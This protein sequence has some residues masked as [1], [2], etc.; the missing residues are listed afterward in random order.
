MYRKLFFLIS[1]ILV[2][3]LIVETAI[4]GPNHPFL[5]VA[6]SNYPALRAL[7]EQLPWSQMKTDAISDVQTLVYNSA[8]DYEKKAQLMGDIVSA[9]ALAY[10]LDPSNSSTYISKVYDTMVN[11][12][13]DLWAG[14]D[15]SQHS[16]TV[17]PGSAFFN[18]VLALDIMYNDLKPAQRADIEA[19]LQLVADWYN[20][21]N[22]SWQLNLYGVRGI[23]A[24]YK[25]DR[26]RIDKAKRD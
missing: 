21:N 25:G 23:W 15:K 17:A 26:S 4:A 3:G 10:I 7:A 2:L 9:G 8:D 19:Q 11:Y 13:P 5:I 14:L 16:H 6:E 24:L 12:W 22:T 18:S 20:S 1:L